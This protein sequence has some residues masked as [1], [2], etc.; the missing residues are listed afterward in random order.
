MGIR[1]AQ[2]AAAVAVL[3]LLAGCSTGLPPGQYDACTYHASWVAEG[4]PSDDEAR[5]A[6]VLN[7]AVGSEPEGS[8]AAA[9]GDFV[10]A[11]DDGEREAVDAAS[12]RITAACSAGAWEPVEG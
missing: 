5:L 7:T 8:V 2:S 4:S 3:L 11:V 9:V 6:R 1:H 10:G 12:D